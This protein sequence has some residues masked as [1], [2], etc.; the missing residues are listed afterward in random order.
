MSTE[1][2]KTKDTGFQVGVRKTVSGDQHTVWD[3]VFSDA[4]LRIW[5]GNISVCELD[6]E[7]EYCL[8]DGTKISVTVFK[9]YS[10][11]RMKWKKRDSRVHSRL[12]L[13]ILDS[14]GKSVIAFHQELLADAEQRKRMKKHWREILCRL[15]SEFEKENTMMLVEAGR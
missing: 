13:R 7:N 12:Q 15:S 2:G 8:S 1:V 4:G 5:L 3:F 6:M 9:P 14:N 11:I 10:H